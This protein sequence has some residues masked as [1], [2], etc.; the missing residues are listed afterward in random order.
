MIMKEK[1]TSEQGRAWLTATIRPYRT[2]ILFLT[3]FT[4]FATYLSLAFAYGVRFLINSGTAGQK[5]KLWI[6]AAVLLAVLFTRIAMQTGIGFCTEKLNAKI[7]TQLRNQAFEKL[8]RSEYAHLQRYHSGELMT[9]LTA[10]VQEVAS[11]TARLLPTVAGMIAQCLGAI[12]ALLAINPLFTG[13][14]VVGGILFGGIVALL[15]SPI[16]KAHKSLLEADG[17]SRAFMQ[18]NLASLLTVKAYGAEKNSLSRSQTLVDEYYQAKQKRN[19]LY[20]SM[21]GVFSLLSNFGLIFAVIWCGVS[22]LNGNTDYGSILS[23]VLL[24]MQ[25][26][27]P[28]AKVSSIIPA[29]YARQASAER[30]S[31]LEAFPCEEISQN[32]YQA[33]QIYEK[34]DS[35]CFDNVD[36]TYGEESVLLGATASVKRGEIVCITGA[37]GNGKTTLFKLLLSVFTPTNGK[38]VLQGDYENGEIRITP[39]CRNLFAYVPQGNFLFSGTVYENL[40]Y[41]YPEKDS[42]PSD[43]EIKEALQAAC[44]E[45]VWELPQKLDTSLLERG[46]GL[47]EGQLQRLAI[48]RALLSKRPVLLLDE[49]T[50]AL[51][52][53]TEKALLDHVKNLQGKTCLIVT[54]RPAA[55][56]Y[57]DQI[58]NVEN[59]KIERK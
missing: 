21:R 28:F 23:I 58:W 54:H 9:R 42:L 18:E 33:G 32:R 46:G 8:L 38:I 45:F 56:A 37:S 31:E 53:Q 7:V 29:I 50:S 55:L 27:N 12:V 48:A 30:L 24:L 35:I 40:T 34:L 19:G 4:V 44:A 41:F 57:A 11:V 39:D 15:R 1:K 22:V 14:Y 6:Y 49:A 5:R 17:D 59:G 20:A 13:I 36:F 43:E 25:L 3:V 52:R 26:Q 10:D 47:S 16:K 51:D 2:F